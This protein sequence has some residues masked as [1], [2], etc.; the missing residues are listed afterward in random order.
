MASIQSGSSSTLLGVV[1]C[2]PPEKL[3]QAAVVVDDAGHLIVDRDRPTTD[4]RNAVHDDRGIGIACTRPLLAA[5]GSGI[6]PTVG[7]RVL[8]PLVPMES[9]SAATQ[10]LLSPY[11]PITMAPGGRAMNPVPN[12]TKVPIDADL[13]SS[14]VEKLRT[15]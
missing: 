13:G 7:G 10:P 3:D 15:M 12:T 1:D 2:G 8:A 6:Q 9:V 5:S 14:L 4:R 11:R